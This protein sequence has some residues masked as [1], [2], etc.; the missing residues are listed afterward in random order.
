MGACSKEDRQ[1]RLSIERLANFCLGVR[2]AHVQQQRS[3]NASDLPP[4]HPR[5][6]SMSFETTDSQ[7]LRG[8]LGGLFH[9][10]GVYRPCKSTSGVIGRSACQMTKEAQAPPPH[11]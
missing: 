5:R 2:R 3:S 10:D 11:S 8:L 4:W 7:E 6:P 9:C 1:L